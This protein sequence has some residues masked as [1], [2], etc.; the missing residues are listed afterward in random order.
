MKI[1]VTGCGHLGSELALGL[2][3]QG[4][5][6]SVVDS[7]PAAF[8]NLGS[9]FAGRTLEGIAFDRDVLLDAGIENTDALAAVTSSDNANIVT[10]RVAR[11]VFHVPQVV[12][13]VYDPSRAA[14]YRKL[15]LQT[16]SPTVWSANRV[17]QIL[18]HS[19]LNVVLEMG[20]GE[21]SLVEI[22]ISPTLAGRTVQQLNQVTET[23]VVTITRGGKAFIPSTSS[24]FL[25]G[26]RVHVAVLTG[27]QKRFET[28]IGG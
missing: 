21:V 16:I 25:P 6:V 27:A 10:A 28:L 7:D 22:E 9:R 13:R 15:G 1:I 3:R 24:A 4:H 19:G 17:M 8:E 14:I 18:G 23:Q 20:S 5:E 12:A 11:N 2:A 26:D